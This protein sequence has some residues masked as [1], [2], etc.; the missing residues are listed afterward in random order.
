[1]IRALHKLDVLLTFH[2]VH[3]YHH[4]LLGSHLRCDLCIRIVIVL[5]F[6]VVLIIFLIG[7]KSKK[8][9]LDEI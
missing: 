7:P 8:K 5:I 4:N 1:M 9:H 6:V 2:H 3:H